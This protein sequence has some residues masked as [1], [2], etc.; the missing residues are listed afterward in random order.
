[1]SDPVLVFTFSLIVL[2]LL[3]IAIDTATRAR[4]K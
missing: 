3:C 1:M 4:R 2:G